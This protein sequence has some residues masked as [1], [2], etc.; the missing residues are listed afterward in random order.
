MRRDVL[1]GPS[2]SPQPSAHTVGGVAPVIRSADIVKTFG[3]TRALDG[4]DPA[5]FGLSAR[6]ALL[7]WAALGVAVLVGL[8][9]ELLQLPTWTRQLSPLHHVPGV[10]AESIRA[11]PLVAL[12][13]VAGALLA[14][15]LRGVRERDLRMD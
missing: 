9:G 13:L 6:A 14:L 2:G 7:A 15:G 10:P 4:L 12:F 3:S 5:L 1:S 11:T 8:F